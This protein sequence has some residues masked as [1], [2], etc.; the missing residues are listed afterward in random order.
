MTTWQIS[1]N[2]ETATYT[3][4]Y[5]GLKIPISNSELPFPKWQH[6]QISTCS[7]KSLRKE[8]GVTGIKLL[9]NVLKLVMFT[10]LDEKRRQKIKCNSIFHMFL[11]DNIESIHRF[12]SLRNDK[13]AKQA[14]WNTALK[15]Y[16]CELSSFN[17]CSYSQYSTNKDKLKRMKNTPSVTSCKKNILMYKLYCTW[18]GHCHRSHRLDKRNQ[19]IR[20]KSWLKNALD[21]H[22]IMTT[23]V[24]QS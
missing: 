3:S 7:R 22:M 6:S 20:Q 18:H 1:Q 14:F 10:V 24:L 13:K 19:R 5:W 21:M 17:L 16:I 11:R 12:V 23:K 15:V 9:K 2:T 4:V 8:S